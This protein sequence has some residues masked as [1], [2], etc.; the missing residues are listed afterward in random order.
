MWVAHRQTRTSL[1][2]AGT[3]LGIAIAG[4]MAIL[5]G[6]FIVYERL[7]T[8]YFDEMYGHAVALMERGENLWVALCSGG[9][10]VC[11][12]WCEG[13]SFSSTCVAS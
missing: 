10:H 4:G 2:A 11:G 6:L 8:L 1:Y 13:R 12:F 3:Y 5:M 7:G 9:M